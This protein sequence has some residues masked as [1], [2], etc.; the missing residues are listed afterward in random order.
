MADDSIGASEKFKVGPFIP[1]TFDEK[2]HYYE[3]DPSITPPASINLRSG[4]NHFTS[5]IYDQERVGSCTANAA[6]AALWFEEK[7]RNHGGDWGD[8]GPSR[9]FIYWLARRIAPV[10]KVDDPN[11]AQDDGSMSRDA[12]KGI[13]VYGA[14]PELDWPYVKCDE[15][16]EEVESQITQK[17]KAAAETKR[18]ISEIVNKKP[19]ATAFANAK[20]HKII[21]YYRL[22]PDRPDEQDLSLTGP[23]KDKI[24]SFLLEN[25]RHCLSEG[26]PVA[27]G[28]WFYLYI[29]GSECWQQSN[30][31]PWTLKDPWNN[32]LDEFHG[33]RIPRH[34]FPEDL[35]KDLRTRNKRDKIVTDGHSVLAVGYDDAKEAVLVQNSWG[36]TWSKDGLFWMPYA[37]ITDFAATH[38]FWTIRVIKQDVERNPP[39]NWKRIQEKIKS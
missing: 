12:M 36:P 17:A 3:I 38:D 25:L 34:T 22:D 16:E 39:V 14:C 15:I 30:T 8:D 21:A 7:A 31:E 19:S 24:G 28:F 37:W 32:K 13:A 23:D 20:A 1:D 4:P 26:F 11:D 10:D 18:R 35:P 9:L 27:F 5:D 29:Y 2:D 6:A 33:Q